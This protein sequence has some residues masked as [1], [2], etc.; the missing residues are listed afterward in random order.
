MNIRL[1]KFLLVF[2]A[3]VA[4]VGPAGR[5]SASGRY[6]QACPDKSSTSGEDDWKDIL[7][8][9]GTIAWDKLTPA[10]KVTY[11]GATFD[12]YITPDGNIVLIGGLGATATI[13][14]NPGDFPALDGHG[15]AFAAQQYS[16]WALAQ[17]QVFLSDPLGYIR[18]NFPNLSLPQA[19]DYLRQIAAAYTDPAKFFDD[20]RNHRTDTPAWTLAPLAAA[21]FWGHTFQTAGTDPRINSSIYYFNGSNC[22]MISGMCDCADKTPAPGGPSV[23]PASTVVINPLTASVYKSAP[24]NPVVVG[25]DPAKRGADIMAD[26]TVPP[27]IYTWYEAI[28]V[29]VD[30]CRA[31]KSGDGALNCRMNSS[32]RVFTG[33]SYS[34]LDHYDCKKNVEFL[35]DKVVTMLVNASLDTSSRQWITVHLASIWY[36][37]NV[38]QPDW[39]IIPGF[40]MFSASCGGDNTC[41]GKGQAFR[42][43]FRDPGN[44]IL[45]LS[46]VTSGTKV[47]LPRTF[48]SGNTF[49]VKVFLVQETWPK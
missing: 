9:D 11:G 41:F 24:Q 13:G 8:P 15:F 10:G 12:K 43:P 35:Q 49:I 32:D 33:V 14:M 39:L 40:G 23:C 48:R 21:D 46:G 42:V 3:F 5:A 30:D 29:Y 37:A 7:N 47:S 26:V 34:R 2:V 20:L 19:L 1:I 45:S 31:W 25:Q 38:Y 4:L 17:A 27:V 36:Y 18:K 16:A 6:D 22:G 44:Y 28:P